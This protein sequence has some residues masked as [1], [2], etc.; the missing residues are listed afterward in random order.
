MKAE[1][2]CA[3]ETCLFGFMK[4][5]TRGET[6]RQGGREGGLPFLMAVSCRCCRESPPLPAPTSCLHYSRVFEATP[7]TARNIT[8]E[9][10]QPRTRPRV[11]H[12]L[13]VAPLGC[14][15]LV[16]SPAARRFTHRTVPVAK[17]GRGTGGGGE[18][19]VAA[20]SPGTSTVRSPVCFR[21]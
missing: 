12:F 9:W 19:G 18:G 2:L 20:W 16:Q 17:G 5:H 1:V 7:V 6:D 15:L 4:A 13:V 8:V 3:P 11:S 21:K 14:R 10:R